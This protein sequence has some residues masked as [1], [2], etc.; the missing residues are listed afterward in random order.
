MGLHPDKAVLIP[1]GGWSEADIKGGPLYDPEMRDVF[2]QKFR[3]KLSERIEVREVDLHIND[4]AFAQAA[5]AAMDEMLM[6]KA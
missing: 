1:K 5:S 4:P 3:E 2:I 6:N